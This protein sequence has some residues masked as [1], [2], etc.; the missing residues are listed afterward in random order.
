MY[1]YGSQHFKQSNAAQCFGRYSARNFHM[2]LLTRTLKLAGG[3]MILS[4]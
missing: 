4:A 2:H 3:S 1:V